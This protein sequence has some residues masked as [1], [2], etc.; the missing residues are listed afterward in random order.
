MITLWLTAPRQNILYFSTYFSTIYFSILV[1]Y[2][3]IICILHQ[4]CI[5]HRG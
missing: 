3:F 5:G 1:N 2:D 4:V